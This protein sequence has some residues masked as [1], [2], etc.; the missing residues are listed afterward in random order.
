MLQPEDRNPGD[1]FEAALAAGTLTF[2]DADLSELD[3]WGQAVVA[4]FLGRAQDQDHTISWQLGGLHVGTAYCLK[5]ITPAVVARGLHYLDIYP[6]SRQFMWCTEGH[7]DSM[8]PDD[9]SLLLMQHKFPGVTIE[10]LD[11]DT[12]RLWPR[13]Q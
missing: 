12:L 4:V 3:A 2:R 11:D 1:A 9:A 5:I 10:R 7:H 13:R 6:D 8:Y